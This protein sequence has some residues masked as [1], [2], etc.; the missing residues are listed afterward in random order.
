MLTNT[1]GWVGVQTSQEAGTLTSAVISFADGDTGTWRTA[2]DGYISS[3]MFGGGT[4]DQ[5]KCVT[6]TDYNFY[7]GSGSSVYTINE[8]ATTK[9]VDASSI[10]SNAKVLKIAAAN[11]A[12]GLP[13]YLAIDTDDNPNN[14]EADLYKYDGASFTLLSMPTG[15]NGV[16]EVYASNGHTSGDTLFISCVVTGGKDVYRSF[17][18]GSSW[19]D[20]GFRSGWSLSDVDYHPSLAGVKGDGTVLIIPGDAISYDLGNSWENIS[21]T[22]NGVAVSPADP[23]LVVGTVGRGVV[24]SNTGTGGSFE[25][26][27]NFG[28]EAVR[29]NQITRSPDKS[30]FYVA[31]SAGLAYTTKYLDNTMANFDKWNAPYGEFP[32]SGAGDDAGL[33]AVAIDPNNSDHVIAGYSNGFTVTHT[34][35][36]GFSNVMPSEWNTTA[37]DPSVQDIIFVNSNVVIAVTGGGNGG[38]V[39]SA[40]NI[41]R[42]TD[43]GDSWSQVTPTGFYFGTSLAMG[44]TAADTVIYAGCGSELSMDAA[45]KGALW[46]STDKG[47]TWTKANV[48]PTAYGDPASTELPIFDIAV[49]PRGTDTLYICAGSNLD[50]AFAVSTDGGASM[51]VVD[52]TGEGAFSSVMINLDSPDTVYTAIRR[53]L[54]IYDLVSDKA[55]L[56]FRGLPGELIPDLVYGSVIAGSSTGMWKLDIDEPIVTSTYEENKGV[57]VGGLVIYPNP[58]DGNFN[59]NFP[60][61]YEDLTGVMVVDLQ[62]KV[63]INERYNQTVSENTTFQ[64]TSDLLS[65]GTYFVIVQGQNGSV[66]TKISVTK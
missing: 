47:L 41:Y 7:V 65:T 63:V 17:D 29:I 33:S 62:G 58:N 32:I 30:V 2:F 25:I 39:G 23:D 45:A 9:L 48:G 64:I 22:N 49:D 27:K 8:T 19:T 26:A 66:S 34:G 1:Q 28:L 13:L 10:A 16:A 59:I 42:S 20:L 57:E 52:V 53:E 4:H 37:Q 12:T 15:I 55:T 50:N 35:V 31:T 6:L 61:G 43:G 40:G 14:Q 44:A 11:N 3:S 5:V 36:S 18:G 56:A 51:T 60:D 21:L 24:V 38:L 54:Y 46:K